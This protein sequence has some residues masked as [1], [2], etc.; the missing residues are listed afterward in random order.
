MRS[1]VAAFH[2]YHE[3]MIICHGAGVALGDVVVAGVDHARVRIPASVG[4]TL[5]FVCRCLFI[6]VCIRIFLFIAL[7]TFGH[8]RFRKFL[9]LQ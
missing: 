6:F 5:I 3:Y 8:I 9:T 2:E 7:F 1:W 4:P